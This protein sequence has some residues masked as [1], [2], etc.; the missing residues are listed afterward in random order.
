MRFP[1]YRRVIVL[2]ISLAS[3]AHLFAFPLPTVA[4][5]KEAAWDKGRSRLPVTA[6]T[7]NW[8][9]HRRHR[10][11][12]VKIYH[13]ATGTRPCPVIIVSHGLGGSREGYAYLGRYWASHGYVSVHVQ[14][15]GS[16]EAVWQ[17]A[18]RPRRAL[19]ASFE[20]PRN[21]RNRARDVSFAIDTLERLRPESIPSRNLL[22]LGRLGVAGHAFGAQTAL[23]IAGQTLPGTTGPDSRLADRR[24]KAAIAMSSPV[25]LGGGPLEDVYGSIH[26]PCL[27]MTGTAD[28][29]PIGATRARHRRLPF[30]YTRGADKYL[31]T[32][33]GADHMTF[34]GHKLQRLRG[35]GDSGYHRLICTSSTAFWQAYLKG[36]ARALAWLADGGLQSVLSSRARVEVATIDEPVPEGQFTRDSSGTS[37]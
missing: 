36:D 37:R 20:N 9:D 23:L 28:D 29:S 1:T 16:D 17:G 26:I 25:P 24:V 2:S 13:P 3:F 22:D 15:L 7:L 6:V 4:D 30:D 12:P 18:L 31:I 5:P 33:S 19:V 21:R 11:V 27:H 34:P 32:F 35:Q 10:A 8:Y 14:H